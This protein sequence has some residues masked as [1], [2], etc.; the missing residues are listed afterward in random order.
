MAL[1]ESAVRRGKGKYLPGVPDLVEGLD[2]LAA[3]RGS[4]RLLTDLMDRPEWVREK[5]AELNEAYFAVYDRIFDVIRDEHDGSAYCAYDLW[6]PG[7]TAKVQCDICCMISRPMF[8]EFVAGQLTAQCEWLDYSVYHLD[9]EDALPHLDSLLA[10]DALDAIEWTPIGASGMID[11]YPSGGSPHWYD[12]YRRIRSAGKG[13]HAV[14]V[15]VNEVVPLLD[16][17]GPEGVFVQ[18]FAAD[19]AEA[20]KLID[21][22]APYRS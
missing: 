16:A 18:V 1:I 14:S 7:K 20:E 8:D 4:E 9:G 12:L 11:G 22:V 6:G 21:D 3:M 17:V 19:E 5:L 15:K 10:I 2:T 13:V